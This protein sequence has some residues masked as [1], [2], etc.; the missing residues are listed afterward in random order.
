MRSSVQHYE[1]AALC[2]STASVSVLV[3]TIITTLCTHSKYTQL[4]Y[5]LARDFT[6]I[7]HTVDTIIIDFMGFVISAFLLTRSFHGI[8]IIKHASNFLEHRIC[9]FCRRRRRRSSAMPSRPLHRPNTTSISEYITEFFSVR[10]SRHAIGSN[11][12]VRCCAKRARTLHRR[13]RWGEEAPRF[14]VVHVG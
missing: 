14:W 1:I 5:M 6:Q 4:I 13:R 9:D 3:L 11:F 12:W 7:C 2:V 8:T 10:R